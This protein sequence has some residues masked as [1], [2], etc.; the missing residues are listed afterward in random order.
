MF[1]KPNYES[2]TLSFSQQVMVSRNSRRG[3]VITLLADVALVLC[4]VR[5][6]FE[7]WRKNVLYLDLWLVTCMDRDNVII[8]YI[9]PDRKV[10]THTEL[11]P[12]FLV[13]YF[14]FYRSL[15]NWNSNVYVNVE[16]HVLY[17]K[18]LSVLVKCYIL[19]KPCLCIKHTGRALLLFPIVCKPEKTWTV[20]V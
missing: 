13:N 19:I 6:S 15:L 20:N 17:M 12:H 2:Y 9:L 14:F 1:W 3:I 4:N 8:Y 18:V 7:E 11:F 16:C 5:M 10:L